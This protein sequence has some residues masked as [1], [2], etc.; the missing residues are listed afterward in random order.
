MRAFLIISVILSGLVSC[1]KSVKNNKFL[2]NFIFQAYGLKNIKLVAS[3]RRNSN[4]VIKVV[5]FPKIYR[6]ICIFSFDL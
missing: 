2:K 3:K 1:K 5:L 6:K 4:I